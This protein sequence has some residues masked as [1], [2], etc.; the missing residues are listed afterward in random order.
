MAE[1]TLREQLTNLIQKWSAEP[2]VDGVANYSAL[3]ESIL[4]TTNAA[5]LESRQY[6]ELTIFRVIAQNALQQLVFKPLEPSLT[7]GTSE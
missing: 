3:V 4:E 6:D 2:P 1:L 7:K 5:E